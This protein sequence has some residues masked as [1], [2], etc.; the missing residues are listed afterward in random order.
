MDG[1]ISRRNIDHGERK[2]AFAKFN[3]R[4]FAPV[5]RLMAGERGH[6][7]GCHKEGVS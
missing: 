6:P 1:R 7:I 2:V 4:G 3:F 5:K